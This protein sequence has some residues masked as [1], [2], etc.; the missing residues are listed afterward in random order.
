MRRFACLLGVWF[1]VTA[2]GCNISGQPCGWLNLSA[3]DEPPQLPMCDALGV[4]GEGG[5][6]GNVAA[7]CGM[8]DDYCVQ[9]SDCC[10]PGGVCSLNACQISG[11][12]RR[13]G[14]AAQADC[15]AIPANQCAPGYGGAA[16]DDD[17][18]A[19]CPVETGLKVLCLQP[20]WG[21]P[22]ADMCLAKGIPC[23]SVAYHPYK[24]NGGTGQ[25]FSCNDLI[26]GFM[27]GYHYPNGDDCYFPKGTPFPKVCTYS[28]N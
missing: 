2:S 3:C 28:G 17:G 12:V 6:G 25:L 8:Q 13:I 22:C 9:D 19:G 10:Q 4:G 14:T 16:G 1:L 15:P 26:V 21:G 7:D 24:P 5:A 23:G 27:C 20:E 18:G 11:N